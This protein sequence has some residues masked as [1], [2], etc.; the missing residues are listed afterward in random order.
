MSEQ[1]R[2]EDILTAIIE[3]GEYDYP[4]QSRCEE[5]LLSIL[6]NTEYDKAPQSRLEELLLELKAKGVG[7]DNSKVEMSAFSNKVLATVTES[8]SNVT[9]TIQGGS[10]D[11]SE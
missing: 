4:P 9:I 1:S 7:G 11:D 6:N 5:I 3:D 2:M 10:I 8:Y